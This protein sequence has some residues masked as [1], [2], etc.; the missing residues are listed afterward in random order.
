MPLTEVLPLLQ[1]AAS[2]RA[3]TTLGMQTLQDACSGAQAI[4]V[5]CDGQTVMAY[6]L[7]PVQHDRG[8][9]LWV[10]AAG[11]DL[12]GVNLTQTIIPVIERQARVYGARQVAI[13]TRR[14]GL[15]AQLQGM[16]YEITGYTLRKNIK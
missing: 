3:D 12:P 14:R 8:A 2:P 6:A 4:A 10:M 9:V 11:G 1:R 16:G 7:R 13:T 5:D 15:V